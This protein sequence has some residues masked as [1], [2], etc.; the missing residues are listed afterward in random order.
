MRG[1]NEA[2]LMRM[3]KPLVCPCERKHT[4]VLARRRLE[5]EN[6]LSG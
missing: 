6:E 2:K 4:D 1:S 3:L 5:P